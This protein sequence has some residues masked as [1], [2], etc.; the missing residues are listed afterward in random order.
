MKET[1]L[2]KKYLESTARPTFSHF[3]NTYQQRIEKKSVS[4][5]TDTSIGIQRHWVK[6]YNTSVNRWRPGKPLVKK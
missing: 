1:N 3:S 4:L 5:A 2:I 6:A